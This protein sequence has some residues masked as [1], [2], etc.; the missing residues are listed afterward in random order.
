M[1][2]DDTRVTLYILRSNAVSGTGE[3]ERIC[4]QKV[5]AAK[6]CVWNTFWEHFV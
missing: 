6:V 4:F 5:T 2:K 3:G 1:V